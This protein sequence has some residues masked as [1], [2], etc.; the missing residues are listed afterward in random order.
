[1]SDNF[2]A[3]IGNREGWGQSIPF[4]VGIEDSRQHLYVIGKTGSGKTTLLKSLIIQHIQAGHGVGVIDPHGDLAEELLD[5]IPPWRTNDVA[6]FNPSDL[7]HPV[8]INVPQD[9]RHL[10]ASGIVE[11]FKGIWKDSWGPRLEYILHNTLAALLDCHGVTMLGVTRMLSDAEY[12]R[13]VV[14]NIKDPLVRSFWVAEFEGYDP[15]YVAEAVAP[16]QNKVGQFLM[17]APV[18]NVL[19]Q[20]RNR[21]DF[22]FVMD[23]ERIFI[24][25]LSKGKLG[26]DKANL[27]GSLVTTQ[28]QLAAMRRA[29]I[30]EE[31]RKDFFLF[32]DE[33]QNFT[34]GSFASILS[35][36]RKYRLCMTLSHQYMDQLTE[37]VRKAVLG[38]V[39]S[40]VSFRVGSTD[41]E[42]L[43]KEFGGTFIAT[44]FMDLANY[45]IFVRLLTNGISIEAFR[46]MTIPPSAPQYGRHDIVIRRSREQFAK[47]REVIEDKIRRW[48]E[49]RHMNGKSP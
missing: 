31:E 39:G 23:R 35:E 5:F 2:K 34:T 33:F 46:A 14:K 1:M 40:I 47:Q 4:G 18:R 30:P 48:S 41:A 27:L 16:V 20:V 15:R 43:E 24:A 49:K 17:N 36:A 12:R 11:A 9:E 45:E 38:N 7:E 28:F 22:R 3:I 29:G 44:Q 37:E 21:I 6:Y 10:V 19:G 26:A 13:R 8:G 32:I 25:N 42:I